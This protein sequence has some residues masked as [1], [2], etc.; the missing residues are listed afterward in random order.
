[1]SY[2]LRREYAEACVKVI[3]RENN[4]P[5]LNLSRTAFTY[6]E[7]GKAVEEALGKKIEIAEVSMEEFEKYLDEANVS[8]FGKNISKTMQG[9][10][11]GGDNGEEN[12]WTST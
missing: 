9:Y 8:S 5:I 6:P 4:P 7:L 11:K 10:V 12:S 1:M 3:L 2:G